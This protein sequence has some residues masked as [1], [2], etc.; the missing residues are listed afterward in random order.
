MYFIGDCGRC[1]GFAGAFV[2]SLV[3]DAVLAH[4]RVTNPDVTDVKNLTEWEVYSEILARFLGVD[5]ME[6][7][8]KLIEERTES[9][10]LRLCSNRIFFWAYRKARPW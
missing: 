2:E 10:D 1:P 3:F 9:G 4:T 6:L 8:T 7:R 5:P